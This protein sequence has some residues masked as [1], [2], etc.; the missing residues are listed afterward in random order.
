M[1]ISINDYLI[2]QS[3]V[4]WPKALAG[5]SW[6]LPPTFTIWLVNRFA[7]IFLVPPD[8]TVHMLDVGTGTLKKVADS[9]AH[10]SER[11]DDGD[12]ANEWLMIPLVDQLVK[13]G[14]RLQTGQCYGFKKP[15]VLGGEYVIENCAPLP[16]WDYLGAYGSIHDQL[17]DVPD[18]GQV[19][20]KVTNLQRSEP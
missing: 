6:M 14:I 12:T 9:R 15:P 16:V 2:D 5:W 13:A 11:I 1:A 7:D 19:V 4:D 20:V 10:F 18:G 17:R 8:A 3:T